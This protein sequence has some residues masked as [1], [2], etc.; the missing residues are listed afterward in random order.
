[1]NETPWLFA[2]HT[3]GELDEYFSASHEKAVTDA[4]REI[5]ASLAE[6]RDRLSG[7][8]CYEYRYDKRR[9]KSMVLRFADLI[10]RADITIK[11]IHSLYMK[12]EM[13]N[14]TLKA[15]IMELEEKS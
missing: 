3:E 8:V 11:Q 7:E 4:A 1:M 10:V 12:S 2:P 5:V 6:S 15:K 14:R 13:D 9:A